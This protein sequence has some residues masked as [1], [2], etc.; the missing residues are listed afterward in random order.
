MGKLLYLLAL[1]LITP[2]IWAQDIVSARSG[3]VHHVEGDAKLD[4]KP[5]QFSN[6]RFPIA[7]VGQVLEIERGFAEVLLTPG[8]FLRVDK[9]AS[10]RLLSNTLE[11][12]RIEVLSG[13]ALVEVDELLKGNRITVQVGAFQTA[14]LKHGLYY[15]DAEAGRLRV[16]DGKAEAAGQGEPLELTKGRTVLF[17]PVMKPEKF[18]VKD[19]KD[20]LFAWSQER[21]TRLALA[22]ISAA[23]SLGGPVSSSFWAWDPWLG[24][25][26]FMPRSGSLGSPFGVYWYNPATVWIVFQPRQTSVDAS[27][28]AGSANS[29]NGLAGRSAAA[30]PASDS[31]VARAT[32]TAAAA[33]AA[34]PAA[35]AAQSSAGSRSR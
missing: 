15:F 30:A 31:G 9:G 25:F 21:A 5:L 16:F 7:G 17:D 29:W 4:G 34:A 18:K 20:S 2:V 3:L 14:L 32:P 8:A 33:P 19:A 28:A 24:M 11:D 23:R 27:S 12:T 13:T 1:V 26:T 10:F 35:P 6:S 22:N